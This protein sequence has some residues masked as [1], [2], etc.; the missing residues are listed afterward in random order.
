MT[1]RRLC[2]HR[3][4][5]AVLLVAVGLRPAAAQQNDVATQRMSHLRR[6][7]NTSMWFAQSPGNYSAERLRSFTTADDLALI[8]SLG[9]DHIRLSIDADPLA[10]WQ[11]G[12][13]SG[14]D[15]VA[16]LDRVIGTATAGGLAV[17]VDIHPESRYKQGLL[18][19]TDGVLHFASLWRVLAEH[20]RETDP[21]LVFFEIMNEPEQPDTFRWQGIQ[22]TVAAEIR[23]AAPRHTILAAGAHWS[24]IDDLL[25]LQSIGIDNV[26]YTF[27]NYEPFAFTHQGA[28]W[29]MSEVQPLRGVPYPST[30]DNVQ[31]LLAQEPT[32]ASRYWLEQY[33][34]ARW[35]AARI[36]RIIS[37]AAQWSKL[38]NAPVYCGEFGV[39][40][41]YA[42]PADRARWL[43]DTRLALEK[44]NIGWAMWD[45]QT[46]FGVVSKQDGKTT[47]DEGV[48]EALGLKPVPAT[49]PVRPT[50]PVR[51]T[52]P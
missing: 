41:P 22:T 10:L 32:Q 12:R 44:Y 47:P 4:L 33:G 39:H 15:F 9:F 19:G 36:D 52:N 23:A 45:Y 5:L 35:D 21:G 49:N 50:N 16:E 42:P 14:K 6:G 24:G 20:Y 18:Q 25:Q 17:I 28:T 38:H 46:N 1:T 13:P 43:H 2:L 29:T 11:S 30:P 8:R 48:V 51:A 26:I 7:I 31:P 3:T 27:H 34:L 37:F 40:R